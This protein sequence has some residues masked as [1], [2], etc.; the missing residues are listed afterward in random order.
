MV[1][2]NDDNPTT[3]KE[4]A[5]LEGKADDSYVNFKREGN[6]AKRG[7]F[8]TSLINGLGDARLQFRLMILH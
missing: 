8:V 2:L 5:E 6:F 1:G 3:S 4:D 7:N